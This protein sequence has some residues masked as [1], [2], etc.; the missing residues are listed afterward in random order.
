LKALS[1]VKVTS[2]PIWQ[3]QKALDVL[4]ANYSVSLVWVPGHAGIKGNEK[5]DALAKKRLWWSVY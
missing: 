2:M 3:W 5:A 4:L 1:A